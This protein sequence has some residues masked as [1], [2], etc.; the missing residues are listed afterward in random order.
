MACYHVQR[1]AYTPYL[2]SKK[3]NKE[4]SFHF[5]PFFFYFQCCDVSWSFGRFLSFLALDGGM[6][7][8]AL[9]RSAH[10]PLPFCLPPPKC[11]T[12]KCVW[13]WN[14]SPHSAHAGWT[15]TDHK[16]SARCECSQEEDY[17]CWVSHAI[18]PSDKMLLMLWLSNINIY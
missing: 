16:T 17:G 1:P 11:S 3:P 8:F 13:H 18:A 5:L 12:E 9:F 14:N 6:D 4:K 2:N 7:R 15:K 10:N